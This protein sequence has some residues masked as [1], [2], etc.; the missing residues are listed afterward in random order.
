LKHSEIDHIFNNKL[1][2]IYQLD[3]IPTHSLPKVPKAN[4]SLS[5]PALKPK[6]NNFTIRQRSKPRIET[7]KD[8]S[9]SERVPASKVTN[10]TAAQRREKAASTL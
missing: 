10:E 8:L 1:N 5:L 4:E 7:S 2:K 9:G 3:E 6:N